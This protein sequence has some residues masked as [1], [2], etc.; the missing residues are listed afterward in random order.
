MAPLSRRRATEGGK[1]LLLGMTALEGAHPAVAVRV[2]GNAGPALYGA[3]S[4]ASVLWAHLCSQRP[5]FNL[6]P[7]E[8]KGTVV[9][10]IYR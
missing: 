8:R 6:I 10:S 9:V 2:H 1:W 5:Y 3:L 4:P 7:H